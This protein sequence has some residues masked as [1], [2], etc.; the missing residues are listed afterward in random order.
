[1]STC[2][3]QF[4]MTP[5]SDVCP[6]WATLFWGIPTLTTN[7]AGAATFTPNSAA[8]DTAVATATA[9]M[10][11]NDRGTSTNTGTLTYNGHGC[12]CKLH[13]VVT[14]TGT[15]GHQA[16]QLIVTTSLGPAL[17]VNNLL[18]TNGTTDATFD[19]PD[20][21]GANIT[22]SVMISISSGQLGV[23]IGLQALTLTAT[24]GNV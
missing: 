3:E 22:V 10:G 19:L 24:V 18:N 11:F 2:L 1:M 23:V 21:G 4:D 16:G 15:V 6:N 7:G 5:A 17:Y 14:Q 13:I 12:H 20:T 8:S 9:P